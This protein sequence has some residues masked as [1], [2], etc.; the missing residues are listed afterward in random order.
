MAARTLS[1]ADARGGLGFDG[2]LT[3]RTHPVAITSRASAAREDGVCP[4][5]F[6]TSRT[7]AHD[8]L[9]GA[10]ADRMGGLPCVLSFAHAGAGG[11]FLT[12]APG[13]IPESIPDPEWCGQRMHH[14]AAKTVACGRETLIQRP[15]R[16]AGPVPRPT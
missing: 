13:P 12:A 16:S 14:P 7:R 3:G 15:R 1:G 9:G 6:Q 11:Q 10:W 8:G 5:A 2:V 4:D